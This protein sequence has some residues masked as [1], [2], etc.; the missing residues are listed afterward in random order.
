MNDNK[1]TTVNTKPVLMFDIPPK[2]W[3]RVA[4]RRWP[5]A[6]WVSGNGPFAF[7]EPCRVTTIH[8]FETLEQAE[9]Y[10]QIP[11]YRCG[12]VCFPGLHYIVDLRERRR[13]KAK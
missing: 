6:A 4:E 11:G 2:D 13:R 7:V 8:L 5:D 9:R 1:M 10:K 3:H 12:G